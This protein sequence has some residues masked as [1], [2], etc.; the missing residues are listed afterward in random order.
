KHGIIGRLQG[1]LRDYIPIGVELKLACGRFE[2]RQ[3][4]RLLNTNADSVDLLTERRSELRSRHGVNLAPVIVAIGEQDN[5]SAFAIFEILQTPRGGS[6]G[7]AY[8]RAQIPNQS[9]MQSVEI[10]NEPIMIECQRTGQIGHRGEYYQAHSIAGPFAD[11][12]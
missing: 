3:L 2:Q 11:K 12:I 8:R 9:D 1:Q 5:D 10:F 4:A 7:V 6:G